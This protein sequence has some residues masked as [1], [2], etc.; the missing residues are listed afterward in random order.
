MSVLS[1][2][3]VVIIGGG[4][5][6]CTI[7]YLLVKQGVSVALVDK[8]EIGREASWA[9]AGMVGPCACEDRDPWFLAATRLSWRMYHELNDELFDVTQRRI[10]LG[11]EGELVYVDSEDGLA[12]LDKKVRVQRDAGLEVIVMDGDEAREREPALPDK[13]IKAACN[14]AGRFLD[15]RA[16]TAII[17]AAANKLGAVMYEGKPVTGLVRGRD[18]VMGVRIGADELHAQT[19]I[20]SAGA[21]AGGIDPAL[22]HPVKPMHGQIMSVQGPPCGLRHNVSQATQWGY[23]TPRADGRVVVGATHELW[24]FVKRIT[25]AGIEYIGEVARRVLPCLANQTI[26][27]IWSGLRPQTPDAL[28]TVGPDPRAGDGYLW[29]AGHASSGMTQMPATAAVLCDLV[30]HQTPRIDISQLTIERY[31][32]NE[33]VREHQAFHRFVQI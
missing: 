32:N 20:N 24:G 6:G 27:D 23:C 7:A 17:G 2:H 22:A 8:G 33:P 28:P 25:P 21:W 15:A 31:L 30:T 18:R 26:I 3:D 12:D 4:A 19:V 13:T 29:A 9:S 16:Y 10:G 14:P 1:A 5:C 11:G